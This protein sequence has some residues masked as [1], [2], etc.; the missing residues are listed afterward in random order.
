MGVPLVP[1]DGDGGA[2]RARNRGLSTGT[3]SVESCIV[4]KSCCAFWGLMRMLPV[5]FRACVKMALKW[6]ESA[7][8]G[9]RCLIG[10]DPQAIPDARLNNA[11]I[12]VKTALIRVKTR[13]HLFGRLEHRRGFF[14]QV[15]RN[16]PVVG[17]Q[18]GRLFLAL[19][20]IKGDSPATE[21]HIAVTQRCRFEFGWGLQTLPVCE[22]GS[23]FRPRDFHADA[24]DWSPDWNCD[25]SFPIRAPAEVSI[26]CQGGGVRVR[27]HLGL[28][29]MG[30]AY[31]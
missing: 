6:R 26:S 15:Q 16:A 9:V 31:T 20:L 28:G 3:A 10:L 12:R 7:L 29:L 22:G 30:T 8:N 14:P 5:M 23:G 17:L 27:G 4:L 25:P 2:W 21:S 1:R 13:A 19:S 11:L 18:A 24:C